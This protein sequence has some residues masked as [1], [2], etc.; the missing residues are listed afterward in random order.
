MQFFRQNNGLQV[1]NAGASSRQELPHLQYIPDYLPPAPV[2][3]EAQK[4]ADIQDYH[5][6]LDVLEILDS[7]QA[8]FKM[9]SKIKGLPIAPRA[10]ITPSQP[11]CRSIAKAACAFQTSPEPNT[12]TEAYWASVRIASQSAFPE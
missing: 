8:F 6:V 5:Y 11:V 2:K 10:I 3:F 1:V 9:A 12:G 4:C 7:H